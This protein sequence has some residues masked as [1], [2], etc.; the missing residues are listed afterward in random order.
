M[1][2]PKKKCNKRMQCKKIKCTQQK[3][4]N[5]VRLETPVEVIINDG[6]T[7]DVTR[8]NPIEHVHQNE[9]IEPVVPGAFVALV[10]NKH[11]D[12]YGNIRLIEK[13]LHHN[14]GDP[15]NIFGMTVQHEPIH[16]PYYGMIYSDLK[17]CKEK[18][19]TNLFYSFC[20]GRYLNR[21]KL[22][23]PFF[24]ATY[25]FATVNPN[26][27]Q[28]LVTEE[29]NP[30][31]TQIT[32]QL[33]SDRIS[34]TY[35]YENE[36]DIHDV[37]NKQERLQSLYVNEICQNKNDQ[38]LMTEHV[39][40]I[41]RPLA[42]M[43]ETLTH[44]EKVHILFHVYYFLGHQAY[45]EFAHNN[46]NENNIRLIRPYGTRDNTLIE[47]IYNEG[48]NDGR[49]VVFYSPYLIRIIGCEFSY[50]RNNIQ[51]KNL[52][53]G[54]QSDI[55]NTKSPFDGASR[56]LAQ[57]SSGIALKTHDNAS[58]PMINFF[59][60]GNV[61][62]F[63]DKADTAFVNHMIFNK[64]KYHKINAWLQLMNNIVKSFTYET[65]SS[66]QVYH[67]LVE[68]YFDVGSELFVD[69]ID[70]TKNSVGFSLE[71]FTDSPFEFKLYKNIPEPVIY[72]Y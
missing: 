48:G 45:K 20:V 18:N 2:A 68:A 15:P 17:V 56:A 9:P 7:H 38:A 19:C 50:Y 43:E 59:D 16:L 11:T 12:S 54:H 57:I 24:S 49:K 8:T 65:E 66:E 34:V 10:Y 47:Y 40:S 42:E 62:T 1:M 22:I 61:W 63:R 28:K 58:C 70:E 64:S 14:D 72:K 31:L 60:F 30:E 67:T 37:F 4:G 52:F 13:K 21:V 6:R 69:E 3:Q 23:S 32:T 36:N 44:R 29:I 46:L 71:M 27:T 5:Q 25:G 41:W 33:L 55:R 53:E 39:S 51:L 26:K 35:N